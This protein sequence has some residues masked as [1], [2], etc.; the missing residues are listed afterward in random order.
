MKAGGHGFIGKKERGRVGPQGRS[1]AAASL[2][3][4]L[5]ATRNIVA[6]EVVAV[7]P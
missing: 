1:S 6:P 7:C 3:Q 2:V 5:S 4:S